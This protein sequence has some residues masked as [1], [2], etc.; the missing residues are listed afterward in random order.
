MEPTPPYSI[1]G[2]RCF[3]RSI[4]SRRG[5]WN[6]GR[7]KCELPPRAD[8][9]RGRERSTF[10]RKSAMDR[11]DTVYTSYIGRIFRKFRKFFI[12]FYFSC[13]NAFGSRW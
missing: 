8:K 13:A 5:R 2:R 6:Y 4:L 3:S 1:G 10:V 11:L 12:F 9:W 7:Q